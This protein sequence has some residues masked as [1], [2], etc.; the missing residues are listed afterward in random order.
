MSSRVI[1]AM[2][3]LGAALGLAGNV[4]RALDLR[5]PGFRLAVDPLDG[6]G[7][8]AAPAG[9]LRAPH[10]A[11]QGVPAGTRLVVLVLE[12]VD[13]R[14]APPRWLAVMPAGEDETAVVRREIVPFRAPGWKALWR[15]RFLITAYALDRAVEAEDAPGE[16]LVRIRREAKASAQWQ[17]GGGWLR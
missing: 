8:L 13:R 10:V 3:L 12:D 5:E 16:L 14:D 9:T 15:G 6:W 4:V 7:A 11:W 17:A 1:M 2:L